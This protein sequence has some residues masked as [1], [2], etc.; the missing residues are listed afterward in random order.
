MGRSVYEFSY[1][2]RRALQHRIFFIISFVLILFVLSYLIFNFLIF[3]SRVRSDSMEPICSNNSFVLTSPVA[4]FK[5]GDAVIVK[6]FIQDDNGFIKKVLNEFVKFITFQQF[7]PF[8]DRGSLAENDS[9][10]RVVGL[11]GDTIYMKDYV[12]YIKPKGHEHFLS[13]F[14][15]AKK[16]YDINVLTDS[17]KWDLTLGVAGD[18]NEIILRD[19]EYFLLCDNRIT[20]VDSRIWGVVEKKFIKGKV[21]LQYY[22][23]DSFGFM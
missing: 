12:L 19:G 17:M 23:F 22:P 6:S 20:G 4:S 18:M 21:L 13:E 1:K 9:L 14:E 2:E 3:P 5:R 7:A 10:R 11:P 16:I 15:L 8:S